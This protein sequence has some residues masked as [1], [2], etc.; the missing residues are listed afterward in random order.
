MS[1]PPPAARALPAPALAAHPGV[2]VS[3]HL[4][5][6]VAVLLLLGCEAGVP[7]PVPADLLMLGIG[8]AVSGGGL[9]WWLAVLTLQLVAV[10][11]TTIL[12]VASRGPASALIGL[13]GSRIGLTT[14]RQA[15]VSGWVERRGAVALVLGR[16]TPGL[17]TVTVISAGSARVPYRRALPALVAGSTVFLQGHLLLGLTLGAPIRAVLQTGAARIV[18]AVLAALLVWVVARRLVR[19][20]PGGTR[21]ATGGSVP[22]PATR[23]TRSPAGIEGACPVCLL[24]GAGLTRFGA[25]PP[26]P[27]RRGLATEVA[28]STPD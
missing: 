15:R 24:I 7:V 4:G 3:A 22:D 26:A 27:A 10:V 1:V 2:G 12:L 23:T 8:A 6:P 21:P 25:A 17:R 20:R 14:Q 19:R 13:I 16:A 9:P 18:A 11:G 5:L 28:A